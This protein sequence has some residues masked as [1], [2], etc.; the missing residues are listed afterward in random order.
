MEAGRSSFVPFRP[1]EE[2]VR[3]RIEPTPGYTAWAAISFIMLVIATGAAVATL[4][5]VA[6]RFDENC[7]NKLKDKIHNIEHLLT[8]NGGASASHHHNMCIPVGHSGCTNSNQCCG[9][10]SCNSGVCGSSSSS[11]YSPTSSSN[12]SHS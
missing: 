5:L 2:R 9:S 12:D 8:S 1:G 4:V 10:Y 3:T 11:S 7:C 6:I